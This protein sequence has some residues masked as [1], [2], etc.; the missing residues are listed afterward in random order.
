MKET[1]FTG[2]DNRP[3]C[4]VLAI[5]YEDIAATRAKAEKTQITPMRFGE[6]LSRTTFQA[7]EGWNSREQAKGN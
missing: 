3:G 7:I 1:N 4:G 2:S 5:S 6:P